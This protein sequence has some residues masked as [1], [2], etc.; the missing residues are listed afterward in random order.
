[1]HII[2]IMYILQRCKV[3]GENRQQP[4]HPRYAFAAP[5][6]PRAAGVSVLDMLRA[7]PPLGQLAL[8]CQAALGL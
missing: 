6:L 3:V 5:Q 4:H 8:C 1:M 2:F 7:Q